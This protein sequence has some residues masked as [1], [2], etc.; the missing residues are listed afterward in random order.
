MTRGKAIALIVVGIILIIIIF[1]LAKRL[2][3]TE[4]SIGGGSNTISFGGIGETLATGLGSFLGFL[5]GG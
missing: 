1:L 3:T 4:S 5:K 2:T